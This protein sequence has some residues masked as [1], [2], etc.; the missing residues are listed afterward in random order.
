MYKI[1]KN[2]IPL[3]HGKSVSDKQVMIVLEN[4][5]I[6][7]MQKGGKWW[8]SNKGLIT[9]LGETYTIERAA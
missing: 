7:A 1:F 3:Y 2:K 9:T 8:M 6:R 4:A 5:R